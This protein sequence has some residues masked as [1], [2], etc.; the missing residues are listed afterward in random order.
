MNTLKEDFEILDPAEDVQKAYDQADVENPWTARRQSA[1][2]IMEVRI[3]SGG[4]D[5]TEDL[6]LL[7]KNGA[8]PNVFHDVVVTLW[9]RF[10]SPE[11]VIHIVARRDKV[12]AIASAYSWAEKEDLQYG[13][14]R[15]LEGLK[16]LLDTVLGILTSRHSVD[17]SAPFQ[18]TSSRL[19]GK[20][21]SS[22]QPSRPADTMKAT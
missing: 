15:Y 5:A 16:F 13:S 8:Y 2:L 22:F 4:K 12:Q 17:R 11:E 9:L 7:L 10:L 3:L 1:A 19:P 20:S 14:D 6:S 18:E 21:D